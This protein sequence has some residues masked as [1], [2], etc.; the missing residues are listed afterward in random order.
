MFNDKRSKKIILVA[1][2]LLNQNSISDGTADFA[3][4]IEIISKYILNQDVGIIQL[5]CPELHCLGIDRG[6]TEGSKSDVLI[7]N[8][9]IRSNLLKKESQIK[10]QVLVDQT[11]F[12]IEEYI[13]HKFKII[14]VIG[15]NRSP[16]CGID[17]TSKNNNEIN[18][19]GVFMTILENSLAKK[20]IQ[21]KMIGIKTSELELALRKTKKLFN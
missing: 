2:C 7:E 1:H 4:T 11:V 16:S 17:S 13:K 5:P 6:N 21:L 19:K 15:I 14:G 10:L 8:T 20:D 12:Q 18:G 9:R 3:A